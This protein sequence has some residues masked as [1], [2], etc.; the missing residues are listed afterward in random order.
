MYIHVEKQNPNLD[1][2]KMLDFGKYFAFISLMK[3]A[4]NKIQTHLRSRIDAPSSDKIFLS[5]NFYC[6]LFLNILHLSQ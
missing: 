4:I 1:L 2:G 6:Q 5:G 3:E